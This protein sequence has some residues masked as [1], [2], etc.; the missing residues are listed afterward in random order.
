LKCKFGQI[1]IRE[2]ALVTKE[3]EFLGVA[4]SVDN[5]RL[6]RVSFGEGIPFVFYFNL[7]LNIDFTLTFHEN[8][9]EMLIS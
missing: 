7:N 2:Q 9:D 8:I 6:L 3:L 5:A 4:N 1:I